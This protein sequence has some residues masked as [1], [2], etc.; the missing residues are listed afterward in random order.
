[1]TEPAKYCTPASADDM[2]KLGSESGPSKHVFHV[3]ETSR[4]LRNG[5]PM[6][7]QK[8]MGV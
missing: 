8:L 2:A 3:H 4:N 7:T 6:P 5:P 1:M